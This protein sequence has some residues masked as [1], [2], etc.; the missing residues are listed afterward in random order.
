MKLD[1]DRV[2]DLFSLFSDLADDGLERW[3]CFCQTGAAR[4]EALLREDADS[5][6]EMEA[7]CAAAAAW[8]YADYLMLE[9]SA[10]AVDEVRV[11]EISVKTGASAAQQD[12]REIRDHF[13]AGVAHLLRPACPAL[14]AVGEEL[15]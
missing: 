9:Q 2:V 8:A 12:G 1:M 11:G 6:G 13:L 10:G 5:S 4:I 15:P 3:R 7:L 14:I